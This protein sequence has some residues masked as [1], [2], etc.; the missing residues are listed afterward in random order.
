MKSLLSIVCA[1]CAGFLVGHWVAP[2]VPASWNTWNLPLD[3]L[4]GAAVGWVVAQ[5]FDARLKAT[6][7]ELSKGTAK[8]LISPLAKLVGFLVIAGAVATIVLIVVERR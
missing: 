6:G 2:R 1:V 5:V 3:A 7:R 4:L 8:D